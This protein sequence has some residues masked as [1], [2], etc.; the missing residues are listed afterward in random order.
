MGK[1]LH[2]LHACNQQQ[3]SES[4]PAE[5][6]WRELEITEWQWFGGVSNEIQ[7]C[8]SRLAQL[9]RSFLSLRINS[10]PLLS[11]GSSSKMGDE[12][13]QASTRT[14]KTGCT[15]V[16]GHRPER[17]RIACS[18]E[19]H[20]CNGW[21]IGALWIERFTNGSLRAWGG[22]SLGLLDS[23]DSTSRKKLNSTISQISKSSRWRKNSITVQENA[24]E[25]KHQISYSS[26]I[27]HLSHFGVESA[28]W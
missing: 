24:W 1:T 15:M 3:S 16:E 4:N 6:T 22:R 20:L 25:W 27:I 2:Q 10:D 28:L 7:S 17:T 8:N 26:R 9:L 18:L 11:W 13:I 14:P 5:I 21:I 12:K 23:S 19:A